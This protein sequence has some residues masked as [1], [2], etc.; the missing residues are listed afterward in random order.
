MKVGRVGGRAGVRRALRPLRFRFDRSPCVPRARETCRSREPRSGERCDPLARSGSGAGGYAQAVWSTG[1]PMAPTPP[2]TTDSPTARQPGQPRPA[3]ARRIRSTSGATSGIQ[4]A[5]PEPPSSREGSRAFTNAREPANTVT[6]TNGTITP[7]G[8]Q[9]Q[10]R[11]TVGGSGDGFPVGYGCA[12]IDVWGAVR[13]NTNTPTPLNRRGGRV[14]ARPAGPWRT[15]AP[16]QRGWTRYVPLTRRTCVQPWLGGR[17]GP[18]GPTAGGRGT[19]DIAP[20]SDFRP[21][22][23]DNAQMRAC[24]GRGV[25]EAGGADQ[26]SSVTSCCTRR[27]MSSRVART[28]SRGRPLGSGRSQST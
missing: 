15:H 28:S 2:D 26:S 19:R 13:A 10:R 27:A 25:G 14:R 7:A 8:D 17:V 18:V 11:S 12:A 6:T 3:P 21:I 5:L 22:R 9:T 4:R 20:R 24:F 23:L 16:E 1:A